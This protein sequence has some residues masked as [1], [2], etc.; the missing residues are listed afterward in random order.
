MLLLHLITIREWVLH[1]GAKRMTR[2]TPRGLS[3][4]SLLLFLYLLPTETIFSHEAC[5][6]H[7]PMKMVGIAEG[8]DLSSRQEEPGRKLKEL[9]RR[10]WG[11]IAGAAPH[12]LHLITNCLRNWTV[13]QRGTDLTTVPEMPKRTWKSWTMLAS[14]ICHLPLELA[15]TA[16]RDRFKRWTGRAWGYINIR[17]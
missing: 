2:P 7:N 14:L 17:A 3:F 11:N 13:L 9:D 4:P 10:T 6:Y 15:G 16:V 12:L 1:K 5:F 8:S